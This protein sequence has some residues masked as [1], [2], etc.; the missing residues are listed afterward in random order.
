VDG[1]SRPSGRMSPRQTQIRA[2]TNA[3]LLPHNFNL[4][5]KKPRILLIKIPKDAERNPRPKPE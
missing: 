3:T 4:T 1:F 5:L 2:S